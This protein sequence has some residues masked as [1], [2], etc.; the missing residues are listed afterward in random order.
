MGQPLSI[1]AWAGEYVYKKALRALRHNIEGM[2]QNMLKQ[3]YKN[4]ACVVHYCY[5]GYNLFK[6]ENE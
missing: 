3:E 5:E 6:E 4:I 1:Q 2:S